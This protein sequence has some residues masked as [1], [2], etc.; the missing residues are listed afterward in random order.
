MEEKKSKLS[1]LTN[2]FIK[3]NPVLVLLLGCCSVLATSSDGINALGMGAAFSAVMIMSNVVIAAIRKI[4]PDNVRIPCF[5]V[6]IAGFVTIVQLLMKAY[7]PAL[8]KSLGL[9][10]PLIV[11][12]CI[13]LGRAEMFASKNGVFDSLLDGIGMGIG[14]TVVLVLMGLIR[15][16]FA[17]GTLFTQQILPESIPGIGI[18]GLP[19]GGFFTF[20]ILVA[21]VNFITRDK[22]VHVR[23]FGE[24]DLNIAR[25]LRAADQEKEKAAK[26]AAAKK[27]AEEASVASKAEAAEPVAKAAETATEAA[28]EKAAEIA[29]EEKGA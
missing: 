16:F 28:A 18:M 5:I 11:V 9:F 7:L 19:P 2:G 23:D 24:E 6:V 3:E 10:I 8:D 27:A 26:E 29:E 25:A 17:R 13:I 1:I 22:A 15:E 20:A 4:I 14:Y 21:L 12:N